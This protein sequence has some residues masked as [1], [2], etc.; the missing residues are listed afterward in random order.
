VTVPRVAS[1]RLT[2]VSWAAQPHDLVLLARHSTPS[3][4]IGL[5]AKASLH[6]I[7]GAVAALPDPRPEAPTPEALAATGT[8]SG[9]ALT[10]Q[11]QRAGD[12]WSR[13]TSVTVANDDANN[14]SHAGPTMGCNPH[15]CEGLD[16]LHRA[17]SGSVA[18]AG[19]G[20]RT[21]MLVTQRRI[22]RAQCLP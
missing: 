2:L 4:T 20:I 1:S 14:D 12:G 8:D 9:R 17:E 22:L 16:G 21:H 6:D 3:L 7:K 13:D 10:A 11:G 19:G 18:S 15:D 5:Y